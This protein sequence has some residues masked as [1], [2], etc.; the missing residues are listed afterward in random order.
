MYCEQNRRSVH[1]ANFCPSLPLDPA[2]SG[3]W[4]KPLSHHE[5]KA[6]AQPISEVKFERHGFPVLVVVGRPVK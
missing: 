4:A 5:S 1:K 3:S 2:N 6:K